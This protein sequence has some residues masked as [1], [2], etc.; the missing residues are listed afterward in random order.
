MSDDDGFELLAELDLEP[1]RGRARR[2][3]AAEFVREL[4]EA[5]LQAL[6]T[7]RPTVAPALQRIRA[8]HH[9]LARCIASG[10]KHTQ[11]SLVTGYTA[12]R[13]SFLC[14]DPTFVALVEDYRRESRSVFADQNERMNDMS[15]DAMELLQ[16]LMHEHPEQ[17][18]APVLLDV[19]KAF[20][21]RTGHG[22]NSEVSLKVTQDLIDRPPRE[23]YEDW[24]ARRNRE[25]SSEARK[26]IEGP[27]QEPLPPGALEIE[28]GKLN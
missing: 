23:T 6:T 14:Q 17:F 1:D 21:D 7:R 19:I 10:M 26:S 28:P 25:L 16:D 15:L 18:T 20:A 12:A 9:S 3:M 5:D 13:I 24:Q 27:P 2:P 22:P 8:S 4:V 11:A